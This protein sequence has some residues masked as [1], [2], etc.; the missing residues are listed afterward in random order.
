MKTR[1]IRRDVLLGDVHRGHRGDGGERVNWKESGGE[2]ARRWRAWR[3]EAWCYIASGAVG[4]CRKRGIRKKRFVIIP[5]WQ[6][7]AF[8]TFF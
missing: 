4:I 1:D 6:I 7:V 5:V 3:E 8:A 2:R